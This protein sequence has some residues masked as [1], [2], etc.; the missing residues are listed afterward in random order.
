MQERIKQEEKYFEAAKQLRRTMKDTRS[1]CIWQDQKIF[2]FFSS[3]KYPMRS[4]RNKQQ[5]PTPPPSACDSGVL[6]FL[7]SLDT[8]SS[9]LQP[10][11]FKAF[12]QALVDFKWYSMTLSENTHRDTQ[13]LAKV[14]A[15]DKSPVH[16]T[17]K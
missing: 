10:A 6:F 9:S 11:G 16:H 1:S 13:C 2:S 5:H 12:G 15:L 14:F 4:K 8:S 3:F 7:P 17:N